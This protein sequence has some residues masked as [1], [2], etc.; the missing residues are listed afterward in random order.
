[1]IVTQ[2]VYDA[3]KAELAILEKRF[4]KRETIMRKTMEKRLAT[5]REQIDA[6]KA[7]IAAMVVP[8]D[9]DGADGAEP[10]VA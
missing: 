4:A 1:M 2:R 8:A 9:V 7:M 6:V 5:S 3:A 10:P